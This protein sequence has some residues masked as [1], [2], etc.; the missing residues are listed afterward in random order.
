[1]SDNT[2]QM[3]ERVIKPRIP[4]SARREMIVEAGLA[5]FA[6]LGYEA[7][8]LGRIATAAGVARTVMYD[9]F[10]SKLALFQTLLET[11]HRELLSYLE[12]ALASSG[13]TR[14]RWY[15]TF[16][17]WFRFVEEQPLS[18]RLLYPARAPLETEALEEH[19]RYRAWS[20]RVMAE[21]LAADARHA[22]LEPETVRARA[23]FAMHRDA[24][25]GGARWWQNHPEATRTE[26]VDAAMAAL[27]TGFGGLQ[28]S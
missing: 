21:L 8:S 19:R 12:A 17:A 25:A 16:D 20:N 9:H 10:P 11:E 26:L 15:A 28:P 24:L 6:E 23:L 14:D 22:G 7:A 3:P 27:Y 2:P 4:A 13:S 18:W 5:E 1:M